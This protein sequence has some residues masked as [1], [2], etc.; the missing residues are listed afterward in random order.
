[1]V[2]GN[3]FTYAWYSDFCWGAPNVPNDLNEPNV[4]N[5][6]NAQN[7]L[8]AEFL[9]TLLYALNPDLQMDGP[10]FHLKRT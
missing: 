6:P 2:S 5:D 1:M 4:P 8:N 7:D 10:P 9:C 3:L